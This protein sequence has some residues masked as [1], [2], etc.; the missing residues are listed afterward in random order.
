MAAP[1]TR[2]RTRAGLPIPPS[3]STLEPHPL[4]L[5]MRKTKSLTQLYG[6]QAVLNVAVLDPTT[7]TKEKAQCALAWEHLEER[8]RIL[9]GRPLPGSLRPNRPKPPYRPTNRGRFV[10]CKGVLGG[11]GRLR[12]ASVHF[13]NVYSGLKSTPPLASLVYC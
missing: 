8:E 5:A 1:K 11:L 13:V 6:M 10:Q 3:A 2:N 7:P 9:R 12:Q 4:T